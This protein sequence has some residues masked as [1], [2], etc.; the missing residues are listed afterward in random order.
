MAPEKLYVQYAGFQ[1]RQVGMSS[2]SSLMNER[3][4]SKGGGYYG[5]NMSKVPSINRISL[6]ESLESRATYVQRGIPC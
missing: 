1:E 5:L 4:L 3:L 6:T 2:C